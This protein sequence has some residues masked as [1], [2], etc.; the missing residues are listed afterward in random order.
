MRK[1][2]FS[3]LVF[4]LITNTLAQDKPSVKQDS[5]GWS[6]RTDEEL[7]FYRVFTRQTG[8]IYDQTKDSIYMQTTRGDSV[9][10]AWNQ[11]LRMKRVPIKKSKNQ[12]R[13]KKDVP[14]PVAES[15]YA[16]NTN[17]IGL[18]KGEKY[19]RTTYLIYHEVNF[20]VTDHLLVAPVV[21]PFAL[22]GRIQLHTP[23]LSDKL[24]IGTGIVAVG[25][26]DFFDEKIVGIG[27][28]YGMLTL[29]TRERNLS[30]GGGLA[31]NTF[32][33]DPEQQFTPFQH[34][35]GMIRASSHTIFLGE[36]Y[37][38]RFE[39]FTG[40]LP[41]ENPYDFLAFLGGR[42]HF[43]RFAI[44][45]GLLFEIDRYIFSRIEGVTNDAYTYPAFSISVRLGK[46]KRTLP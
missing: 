20:G 29:G 36:I 17:A 16:A 46:L 26:Y 41:E 27:G 22:G 2:I 9:V 14:H 21:A 7:E 35:S 38:L 28:L 23:I 24:H 44:G 40:E 43:G 10:I 45:Y 25:A 39:R 33:D 19:Y 34:F 6:I 31:M 42:S 8:F 30:L 5:L 13:I 32:F 18:K 12:V 15:Q 1:V 11:V 4:T 37:R 3:L